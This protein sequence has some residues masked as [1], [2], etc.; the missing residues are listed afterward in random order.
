M[1]VPETAEKWTSAVNEVIIG[2][3]KEEGGTRDRNVIVGGATA[4]PFLSYEGSLGHRP[5]IAIEVWDGGAED[6][7]DQLRRIYGDVMS[8]PAEWARKAV[9]FGADLI[10]LRLMGAHPD[11]ANHS[12]EQCAKTVEEILHAVAV[13]LVIWGCGVDEKDGQILPAVSAAARGENCLIGAARETNYRTV[14]AVC[15]A[16]KHKLLAESPLDI[17]IAK[18]VNILCHDAGFPLEEIVMFP[19]TGALGYGIDYVYS[20]QER[21]R[22]AGLSG[23]KLLAQ[24]VLGDIGFETWRAK[25]ARMPPFAG[26]TNETRDLGGAMWEAATATVL[27]QAG[28]ELLVMRHPK[29]VESVKKMIDR[30]TG[31]GVME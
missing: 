31:N 4:L 14:V 12:P 20:I 1:T 23:D 22:L 18:Q 29:A 3:T 13:P 15:H 26:E 24:P 19:T 16:D 10:C 27:L 7:P 6:W 11:A 28:T 5:A 25:E 17:N 8:S 2:A 30:L 21:G 9:D